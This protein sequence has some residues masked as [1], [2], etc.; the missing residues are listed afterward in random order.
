MVELL[1]ILHVGPRILFVVANCEGEE[2]VGFFVMFGSL[3]LS[4]ES[5]AVSSVFYLPNY[6]EAKLA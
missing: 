3:S 1:A 2:V 4:R 6:L 5:L